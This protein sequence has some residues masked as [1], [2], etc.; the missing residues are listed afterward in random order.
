MRN[1]AL[2]IVTDKK[3]LAAVVVFDVVFWSL[4]LWWILS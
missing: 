3:K 1:L 2:E 4:V